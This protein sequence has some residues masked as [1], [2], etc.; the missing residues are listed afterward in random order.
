MHYA[1]PSKSS[2]VSLTTESVEDGGDGSDDLKRTLSYAQA[3]G[4]QFFEDIEADTNLDDKKQE[5]RNMDGIA[6]NLSL[7]VNICLLGIKIAVLISSGSLT[8][9]Q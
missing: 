2:L 7:G 4:S 3:M 9:S 5:K 8:V 6:A 1:N